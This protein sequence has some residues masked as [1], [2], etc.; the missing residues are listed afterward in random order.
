MDP[1]SQSAK[2]IVYALIVAIVLGCFARWRYLEGEVD[3]LRTDKA[4]LEEQIA[5]RAKNAEVSS[6]IVAKVAAKATVRKTATA[7][8]TTEVNRVRVPE[9]P[10]ECLNAVADYLAPIDAAF[11]GLLA[12]EAA[13]DG[14]KAASRVVVR[15]AGADS[16]AHWLRTEREAPVRLARDWSVHS[17]GPQ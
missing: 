3:E 5:I 10:K 2:L 14:A 8:L 16:Q 17:G 1:Y 4:A 7:K 9:T 11:R 13:D 6:A 12:Q 15:A